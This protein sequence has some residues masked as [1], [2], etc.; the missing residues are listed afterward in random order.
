MLL[1]FALACHDSTPTTVGS[2]PPATVPPPVPTTTTT[3][4]SSPPPQQVPMIDEVLRAE[5]C[6]SPAPG[7]PFPPGEGLHKVT[8]NGAGRCNDGSSPA[9]YVRA[10][11]DPAHDAD[12]VWFFDGGSYCAG[13]ED[14]AVRFCGEDPPFGARHMSTEV[15]TPPT[16]GGE[17]ITS[18][19]PANAF[20]G[21]NQVFAVYCTS[22]LWVGTASDVVMDTREPAYRIHFEG[23]HVAEDG[24]AAGVT[25][26]TSDDGVEVLPSLAQASTVLVAGTSAGVPG[27][28]RHVDRFAEV[29]P[30]AHTVLVIDSLFDPAPDVVDPGL[31]ADVQAQYAQNWTQSSLYWQPDTLP[32]C[33][34]QHPGEDGW[35]CLLL[36]R[37]LREGHLQVT[38]VFY[39]HDLLDPV[40]FNVFEDAGIA[41]SAYAQAAVETFRFYETELPN[42]SLHVFSCGQ[43]TSIDS[44][45]YF[46]DATVSDAVSGGP[47]WTEHDALVAHLAGQRVVAIDTNPATTSVCTP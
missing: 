40:V 1:T 18:Q 5:R 36:D 34:E 29:A 12:W 6:P 7:E 14:C 37:A 33:A 10:A 16:R 38:S 15:G 17:G 39:H 19:N 23:H 25:G 9:L 28:V 31:T 32:A 4:T 24:I 8:L 45:L 47:A 26:L 3:T 13:Q 43:H 41:K 22:D 30:M 44:P 20:A 21:W 42:V 35:T 46:F 11:T 2:P 27:A